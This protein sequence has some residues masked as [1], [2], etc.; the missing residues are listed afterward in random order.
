MAEKIVR[1]RIFA[2]E[3]GI[4]LDQ[5]KTARVR[6]PLPEE[7][8]DKGIRIIIRILPCVEL[9]NETQFSNNLDNNSVCQCERP[10][11]VHVKSL[12][13]LL[14]SARK[15]PCRATNEMQFIC[16]LL[17]TQNVDGS[18]VVMRKIVTGDA[19]IVIDLYEIL[20]IIH[21][22]VSDVSKIDVEERYIEEARR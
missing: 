16:E 14:T 2:R 22:Q 12:A 13:E 10:L 20:H 7:I 21:A 19:K 4:V 3:I 6:Y 15:S 9:P 18:A 8:T 1:L 17:T 5:H 11:I